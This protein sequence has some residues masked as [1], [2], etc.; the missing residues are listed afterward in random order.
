MVE[1][2]QFQ[3]VKQMLGGSVGGTVEPAPPAVAEKVLPAMTPIP[4]PAPPSKPTGV[5]QPRRIRDEEQALEKINEAI[6]LIMAWNDT[7]GHD[8]NH[9]W[10]I[11]VP[12]ILSL[13]RGSGFSTSQGRVQTAMAN[14][15]EEIDSHHENHGLGQRHNSRHDL[16]ITEDIQL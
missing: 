4:Q 3:Q 6:N 11:S 12:A 14:R 7:P 10:F 15:K 2:A 9:K 1:E 13:M 5:T 8:S 16:P